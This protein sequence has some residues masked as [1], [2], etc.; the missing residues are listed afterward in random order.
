MRFHT[1]VIRECIAIA[2]NSIENISASVDGGL[3]GICIKADIEH[4]I[5]RLNIKTNKKKLKN[6]Q[7][8]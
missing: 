1:L 2:Y 3:S 5:E 4:S 8:F 7:T 6:F